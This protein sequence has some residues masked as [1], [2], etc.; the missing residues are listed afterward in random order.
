MLVGAEVS[1]ISFVRDYVDVHFDGPILRALSSPNVK[2]AGT[3]FQFPFG[4]SRDGLCMLIGKTV[5]AAREDARFLTLEF[6]GSGFLRI[7]LVTSELGPEA[8][9][10]VPISEG[11]LDVSNMAIWESIP[12]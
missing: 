7:P 6:D 10:L 1:G 3:E 11:R 12:E 8:A 2:I 4:G 5:L 9:H